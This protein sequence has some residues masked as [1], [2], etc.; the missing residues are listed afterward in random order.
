MLYIKLRLKAPYMSFSIP[1]SMQTQRFS[2]TS[3][4][5]TKSTIVG[6]ICAALG[7]EK[8]HGKDDDPELIRRYNE[9]YLPKIAMVDDDI[10]VYYI[11]DLSKNI[12]IM[13]DFQQRR[14]GTYVIG[15]M[16]AQPVRETK[17]ERMRRVNG[18]LSEGE[19]AIR[20]KNYIENGDFTVY[21]GTKREE[22]LKA[23]YEALKRPYFSPFIGRKCC[24]PA[25]QICENEYRPLEMKD[26]EESIG[27]RKRVCLCD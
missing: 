10:T 17:Y 16:K 2:G 23:I 11:D 1:G 13:S 12:N 19:M 9:E 20:I 15:D 4:H 3:G 22:D 26:I 5:P 7:I 24:I 21:V 8:P 6:M 14:N 27:G 18:T 25:C